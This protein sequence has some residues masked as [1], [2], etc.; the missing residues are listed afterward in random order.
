MH[1]S[2]KQLNFA[3]NNPI[4]LIIYQLFYDKSQTNI[5]WSRRFAAFPLLIGTHT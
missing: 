3:E 5:G 4:Y 2:T 1:N